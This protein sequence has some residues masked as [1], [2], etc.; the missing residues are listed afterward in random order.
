ML[1]DF[2][3]SPEYVPPKMMP[4]AYKSVSK[5]QLLNLSGFK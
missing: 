2:E 5:G 3:V 1:K 4:D